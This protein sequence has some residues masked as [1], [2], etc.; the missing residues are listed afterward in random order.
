[1]FYGHIVHRDSPGLKR[2][3]NV[4]SPGAKRSFPFGTKKVWYHEPRLKV[5]G[6]EFMCM[7]NQLWLLFKDDCN[8][9]TLDVCNN[10][11][12]EGFH[13]VQVKF[14]MIQGAISGT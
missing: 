13:T 9:G 10:D 12:F 14:V 5:V 4:R 1:M 7:T 2:V 6:C 8:F 11:S 3:I